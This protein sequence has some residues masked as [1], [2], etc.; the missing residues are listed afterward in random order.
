MD[1]CS[2]NSFAADGKMNKCSAENWRSQDEYDYEDYCGRKNGKHQSKD[3]CEKFTVMISR[4]KSEGEKRLLFVVKIVRMKPKRVRL[5]PKRHRRLK[6]K[7]QLFLKVG[8]IKKVKPNRDVSHGISQFLSTLKQAENNK[9]ARK[10]KIRMTQIQQ[11]VT[12][13]STDI[14]DNCPLASIQKVKEDNLKVSC[15]VNQQEQQHPQHLDHRQNKMWGEEEVRNQ[16]LFLKSEIL[17]MEQ[18]SEISGRRRR[19]RKIRKKNKRNKNKNKRRP[20]SSSSKESGE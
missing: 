9:M 7:P 6:K 17:E 12:Q 4:T 18:C 11:L 20:K 8:K 2:L 13:M 3:N 14:N 15:K 10:N 1:N 5:K 19:K 16:E